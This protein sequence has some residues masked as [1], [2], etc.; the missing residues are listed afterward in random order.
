MARLLVGVVVGLLFG[1]VMS[2]VSNLFVITVKAATGLREGSV[3]DLLA[4]GDSGLTLAPLVCLVAAALI[5]VF[6]RTSLGIGRWHGPA[7]AFTPR[8]VPIMNSIFA[9]ASD[10]PRRR[11]FRPGGIIGQYGPLV[12]FG[13]TMEARSSRLPDAS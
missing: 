2:V 8:T 13:A 11:S 3:A 12:H 9:P 4:I 7:T 10:R 5:V 6:I 1:L